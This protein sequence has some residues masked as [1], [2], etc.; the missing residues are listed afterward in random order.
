MSTTLISIIITGLL[1]GGFF[2]AIAALLN[3]RNESRKI[4]LMQR[5]QLHREEMDKGEQVNQIVEAAER[6]VATLNI[7]LTRAEKEIAK[8]EQTIQ[9]LQTELDSL[10]ASHARLSIRLEEMKLAHGTIAEN[11]RQLPE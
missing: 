8:L 9:E 3:A 2:A 11:V 1:S 5:D 7:A 4:P 6:S 10:R